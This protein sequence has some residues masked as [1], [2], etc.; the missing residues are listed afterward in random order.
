MSILKGLALDLI[1][2]RRPIS[3]QQ[4][5]QLT[6]DVTAVRVVPLDGS[7][8]LNPAVQSN[9]KSGYE[10]YLAERI[11]GARFFDIDG[12]K[13]PH[14]PYPHMLPDKATFDTAMS[15]L[16]IRNDDLLVVYDAIGNFS[17]P[18]AHWMLR[19]FR[20][21]NSLLLDNFPA[22]KALG[23]PIETGEPPEFEKTNYVSPGIDE[24]AVISYE[25]LRE[26]ACDQSKLNQYNILDARPAGRFDGSVPEPRAGI[27]SGHVPGA[28]S[29]PFTDL[30][31]EKKN[32]LSPDELREV[33]TKR[34][35]PS[36]ET[37]AMCGTGVT[38]CI[39]ESAIN[40]ISDKKVKVYDGSW[41]EWAQ[42]ADKNMIIKDN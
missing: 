32:F 37:I 36:K 31:D 13:D 28:H 39:I 14:S 24:D 4:F 12:I 17:A 16:G 27:S 2:A 7:W 21:N 20:H 10:C 34:F 29:V 19:V 6:K 22:Y 23:L 41:T 26:I 40:Q 38:A 15:N 1:K 11:P 18:R 5:V 9:G 8:F 3:P 35:D 33:L 25:Q 42:R 30:L